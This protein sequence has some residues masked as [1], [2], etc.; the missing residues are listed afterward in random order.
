[1]LAAPVAALALSSGAG[2][3]SSVR[4]KPVKPH[5]LVVAKRPIYAFAQDGDAI[6]WSGADARVRVRVLSKRTTSVVGKI[7]PPERALAS[8][9]ALA[10][11]QALWAWD[12]GGNDYETSIMR[13]APGRPPSRVDV[14]E[15]GFRGFGD[16]ERFTGIAGD[17][18]RLGYGWVLEACVNQPHY[19]CDLCTPLGTCPLGV[20]GGGVSP[21]AAHASG[22]R[23]VVPGVPSPAVFALAQGRV[24]VA[25]ARS[26]SPEGESVS[27]AAED[28]P[29][30]VYDFLGRLV[31]RVQPPGLVRDVALSSR[32]LTLILELSNG[33]KRIQQYAVPSGTSLGGTQVAQGAQDLA[34]GSAGTIFRIG[35]NVYLLGSTAQKPRRV[36]RSKAQPIG[37]SIEG[38]RIAWAVNLKGRGRIVALTLR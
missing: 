36:W 9:L 16:G 20:I 30:L 2:T 37:L 21:V 35:S 23:P 6:G 24:A 7:D 28:G 32:K 11:R 26:P 17:G 27:Q 12:S 31:L 19:L 34:V 1:L 13:G 14:L 8:V 4:S 18:E 25:P 33:T 15:G 3:G 22:Q 29:V 10:R 38:R 5:T